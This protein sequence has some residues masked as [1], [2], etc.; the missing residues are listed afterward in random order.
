MIN[1]LC[2]RYHANIH[3]EG[4]EIFLQEHL[5]Q[6]L[7]NLKSEYRKC[8]VITSN[9]MLC[10]K[11]SVTL[12]VLKSINCLRISVEGHNE[13]LHK[14]VRGCSIGHVLGNAAF[15]RSKGIDV[16]LRIT[17]NRLNMDQMFSRVI[18]S[19]MD[20][21]FHKFQIYEMQAVGN[22]ACSDLCINHGLESFFEDWIHNPTAGQVRVSL[23]ARRI[24]EAEKYVN[25]L[26]EIGITMKRV[27]KEASISIGADGAVRICAW[28]MYSKPLINL[29]NHN[30]EDLCAIIDHQKKQHICEYCT[31]LVLY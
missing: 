24:D 9:G 23:A 31:K 28:D 27:G 17:L 30:F 12:D 3:L 15:Y 18:P 10:S 20:E 29:G 19:L 16:V 1:F 14:R 2:E 6:A 8:V 11:D 22:G 25:P 26:Q 13:E 21:G 4:G 7:R 5:I